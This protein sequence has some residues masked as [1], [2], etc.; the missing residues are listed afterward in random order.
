MLSLLLVP[1]QAVRL[2][3]SD[4]GTPAGIP[5]WLLVSDTS[6]ATA[7]AGAKWWALLCLEQLR[8][9]PAV[10]EDEVPGGAELEHLASCAQACCVPAAGGLL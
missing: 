9:R 7:V 10:C 5:G 4:A 2:A 6:P 8:H 3:P 1:P